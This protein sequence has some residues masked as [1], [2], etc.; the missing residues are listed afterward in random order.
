[1]KLYVWTV[2]FYDE[3]E[4]VAMAVASNIDEAK[5]LVKSNI[6]DD[7]ESYTKFMGD[8]ELEVFDIPCAHTVMN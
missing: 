3:A 4:S 6:D 8:G 5:L 1:M 2:V 7:D